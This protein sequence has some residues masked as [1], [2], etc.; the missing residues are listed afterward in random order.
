MKPIITAQD[1]WSSLDTLRRAGDVRTLGTT[2][3]TEQRQQL[4]EIVGAV[5]RGVAQG[6]ITDWAAY[7]L[8]G[9][10]LGRL[11]AIEDR[12]ALLS[13]VNDR[14][15]NLLPRAQGAARP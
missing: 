5:K 9:L 15:A 11:G 6:T 7:R 12:L 4:E 13:H 1:A 8:S 10:L 14:I 3:L 2:A